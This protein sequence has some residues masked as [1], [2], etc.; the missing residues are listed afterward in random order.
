MKLGIYLNSQHPAGDDPARRFAET[1]EQVR[2][3]SLARLRF[4]LGRRAS[5]HA[6]LPL[7]PAARL[8]AAH[9]RRRRGA[10]DRH[11]RHPAARCTTRSS[12]PRSA[13][14]WT[15]SPAASSCSASA[16][17]IGPEE[18]EMYGVP[19][20]ERVSRLTE[21]VEIITRLWTEDHVTHQG[22][23]WQFSDATI[24][25]A[26]AAAAAPAH[27]HRRAGRGA[28][29]K[30]AATIGDGWLVVPIPTLDQLSQADGDYTS[31]RARPPSCRPARTSADCSRSAAAPDEETAFRRVAPH[32]IE[33]VQGL[34]LVGS[35]GPDA[36]PQRHT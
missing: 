19:M 33:K 16:S 2:L 36:R 34:F 32:L 6:R 31:P 21:G 15:S 30:R 25:A 28:A 14:S 26:P 17:A 24:R 8:A 23:H 1:L 11:Q 10:V 18:Y 27:H 4:D 3:D 12:W 13:P 9:R 5:R 20:S 7:L 29:I 22:R 35:G